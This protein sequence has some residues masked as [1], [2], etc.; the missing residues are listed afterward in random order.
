MRIILVLLLQI[1]RI[2]RIKSRIRMSIKRNRWGKMCLKIISL[3]KK[4]KTSTNSV[5]WRIPK[6][7]SVPNRTPIVPKKTLLTTTAIS[8]VPPLPKWPKC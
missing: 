5:I 3:K 6:F 8:C 1:Q 4:M 7:M 2:I